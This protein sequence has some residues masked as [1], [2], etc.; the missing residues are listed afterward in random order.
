MKDIIYV[1]GDATAPIGDDN[2]LLIHCC[3]S[4]GGWGRGFVLALNQRWAEP[5]RQYKSW[6]QSKKG[7]KLGN[8]QFVKVEDDIVV[9]NMIGQ[10]GIKT[11]GKVPPI[12]YGAIAKCLEKVMIAAKRNDATVHAPK[13]G[14]DLAGGSWEKIEELIIEH[15]SE[16]DIQVTVYNYNG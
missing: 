8:V 1:T 4:I 12:R 14:S 10:K 2:K 11:V 15:L 9:C 3:N 6:F 13:F 5:K 7:F 16:H